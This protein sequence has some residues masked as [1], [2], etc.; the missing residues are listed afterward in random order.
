MEFLLEKNT[1]AKK[2]ESITDKFL[3]GIISAKLKLYTQAAR[4]GRALVFE[5]DGKIVK[6]VPRLPRSAIKSGRL[7]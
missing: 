4:E 5:E 3:R 6:R 1:M 2:R 7:K